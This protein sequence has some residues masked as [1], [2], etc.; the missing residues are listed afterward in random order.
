MASSFTLFKVSD[1]EDDSV[2]I[3]AGEVTCCFNA[4]ASIGAGNYDSFAF[5]RVG[6]V[7]NRNESIG[8]HAPD[9]VPAE[10]NWRHW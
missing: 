1:G 9:E 4:D 7:G 5:E 3:E 8:E 2:S 10:I 6:R